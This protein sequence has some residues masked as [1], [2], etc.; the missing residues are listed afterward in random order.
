MNTSVRC[1]LKGY[2]IPNDFITDHRSVIKWRKE[3]KD[4]SIDFSLRLS[5]FVVKNFGQN[6][7]WSYI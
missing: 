6:A 1:K 5:I 4:D 2:Q 3:N 7:I